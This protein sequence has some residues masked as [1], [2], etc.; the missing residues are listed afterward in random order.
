MSQ[1][2]RLEGKHTTQMHIVHWTSYSA[3]HQPL[4]R[5]QELFSIVPFISRN[6]ESELLMPSFVSS[7]MLRAEH[8]SQVWYWFSALVPELKEVYK[9]KFGVQNITQT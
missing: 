2:V 7:F 1:L 6:F 8:T 3:L 5:R 4:T 9:S